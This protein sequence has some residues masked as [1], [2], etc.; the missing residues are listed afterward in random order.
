MCSSSRSPKCHVARFSSGYSKKD[1]RSLPNLADWIVCS[2]VQ[3]TPGRWCNEVDLETMSH[4]L[5]LVTCRSVDPLFE[6][7]PVCS[8]HKS[9]PPH[10]RSF[11]FLR[12]AELGDVLF[13]IWGL[14]I[15]FFWIELNVA[16]FISKAVVGEHPRPHA[17]FGRF[18]LRNPSSFQAGVVLL[19]RGE[20]SDEEFIQQNQNQ[21]HSLTNSLE[22]SWPCK[23]DHG[24]VRMD[25][26]KT[27]Q[28]VFHFHDQ[29]VSR[30]GWP[31]VVK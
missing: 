10:G 16:A 5:I 27:K 6:L 30:K 2:H 13:S 22:S 18:C 15:I 14:H 29:K 28:V 1:T 12:D 8:R 26:P 24:P 11:T 9:A 25:V 31:G 23:D 3:P 19:E 7:T 17:S 21:K 4:Q 20:D